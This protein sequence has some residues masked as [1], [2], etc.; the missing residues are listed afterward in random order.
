MDG[1]QEQ[2]RDPQ[3]EHLERQTKA[4][5]EIAR[6]T[7]TLRTLAVVSACVAGLVVLLALT[8]AF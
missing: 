3:L 6:H 8:G 7:Y 1:D 2:V 5:E 4:L